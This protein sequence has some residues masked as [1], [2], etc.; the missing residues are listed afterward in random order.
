[1]ASAR[2]DDT[3]SSSAWTPPPT[4]VTPNDESDDVHPTPNA[5]RAMPKTVQEPQSSYRARHSHE[6]DTED[7]G[8]ESS[9]TEDENIR[10]PYPLKKVSTM[11]KEYT[12]SEE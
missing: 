5:S 2:I 11:S 1:M 9:D 4:Q 7:A 6:K 3:A 12:D 10:K 8:S